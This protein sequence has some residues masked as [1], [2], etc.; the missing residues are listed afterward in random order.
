MIDR[1]SLTRDVV[2]AL[3]FKALALLAIYFAFFGSAHRTVVTEDGIK[4]A[5]FQIAPPNGER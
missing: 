1:K 3:V 4:T 5:F 2:R